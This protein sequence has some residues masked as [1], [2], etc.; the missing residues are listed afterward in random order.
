[1]LYNDNS[2]LD[3]SQKSVVSSDLCKQLGLN[4]QNFRPFNILAVLIQKT[5]LC[6]SLEGV[7][8]CLECDSIVDTLT[9]LFENRCYNITVQFFFNMQFYNN[10]LDPDLMIGLI[11]KKPERNHTFAN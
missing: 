2:D 4:I 7:I 6:Y 8:E 5:Q 3:F 10:N 9:L 1:M 11:G